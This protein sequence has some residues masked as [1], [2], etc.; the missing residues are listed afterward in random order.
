MK[1]LLSVLL[2]LTL[3]ITAFAGCAGDEKKELIVYFVPSRDSAEILEMTEPLKELLKEELNNQG[4]SFETVTIEVGSTY[5]AVGEALGAGTA[6]VGLIPGGTYVLYAEDGID[7]ALTATRYAISHDEEDPAAW[8]TGEATVDVKDRMATYYRS[9]IVTGPSAKG[10]ELQA[11]IDAGEEITWEDIKDA[12]WAV[13]SS[14]S[15]A[16]YIYPTIWLQE[17]FGKTI[18]DLSNVT[19]TDGY[20]ATFNALAAET[21]DIG[22]IYADARMHNAG[23]WNSNEDGGFGRE[24]EVWAEVGVLGVT[25]PIYNDT[26]SISTKTVDEDLKAAIQTAFINIA[27]TEAGLEAISVYSHLGYKVATDADYDNERKAQEIIK[28]L[29]Q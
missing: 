11:K 27:K 21:A 14:S 28:E 22:T 23:K 13:R 16:G 8:S 7:V 10:Q 9:L 6:D 17:N 24:A 12:K 26:V 15:S 18:T 20:G 5:E 29:S 1:K 3:A 25:A 2:V 19:T 4:Y